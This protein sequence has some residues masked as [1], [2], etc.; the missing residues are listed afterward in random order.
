MSNLKPGCVNPQ[1]IC[2][3]MINSPNIPKYAQYTTLLNYMYSTKHNY[4]FVVNR[5]PDDI[6]VDWKWDPKNE[7]VSVWYKPEFI[8]KYLPYYHIFVFVDSDAYFKDINKTVEDF[9]KEEEANTNPNDLPLIYVAE[10]CKDKKLCWTAG[11]NTGVIIVKNTPKTFEILN[12]WIKGPTTKMCDFWKYRHTREQGCLWELKNSKYNKE[13]KVVT[14]AYK[15][16]THDGDWIVHLAATSSKVRED[17]FG[18]ILKKK[19]YD[20]FGNNAT[21]NT[22]SF[23]I[24]NIIMFTILIMLVILLAIITMPHK[25]I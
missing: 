1:R 23:N 16:G 8:K 9:L 17:Y 25:I 4:D 2:I 7:Y 10:D 6:D 3:G 12:E 13:I 5:C 18:D 14:P 24:I 21:D 20:N 11:P 22:N 19:F 15:L